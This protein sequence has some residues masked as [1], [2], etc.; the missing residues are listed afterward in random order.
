MLTREIVL[1]T[2]TT[3]LSAKDG[4]RI[5]EIGAVEMI[6]KIVTGNNFHVY[7]D[8]ERDMPFG[9]YKIHGL[10]S[11]FLTGKPKFSQIAA[12]FLDFI[13][14]STLI[15][16]NAPFDISFLN[17]EL[18]LVNQRLLDM[19]CVID[20]VQ[21]AR[22]QFQ[23]AK[24]NLDALCKRFK[25]DNSIRTSHGALIDAKL[26]AQV[27]IELTGGKQD[28]FS[29]STNMSQNKLKNFLPKSKICGNGI[30]IKPTEEELSEHKN[31]ILRLMQKL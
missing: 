14:D 24:V 4:H 2:E 27:Y 26:L 16:H 19:S 29:I 3:G 7:I 1:D 13:Q 23:G 5:V 8:P 11:E 28:S 15:I 10:S 9:A 25:I 22:K 31:F 6:G 21:M 17:Y 30:R 18:G 12:G 20:T